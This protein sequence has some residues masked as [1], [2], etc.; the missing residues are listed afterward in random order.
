MLESKGIIKG[1]QRGVLSVFRE[2]PDSGNFFLTG[3]TALSDFY[4]GHRLS[5]DLVLFTC[6]EKLVR[7]F[8]HAL[9]SELRKKFK[10]K[11]IRRFETF[12]EFQAEEKGDKTIIQLAYDTPFRLEEP[13]LCD[14]GVRVS[15][16]DDLIADKLLAFFGRVEPRDAVDV[17]F[18]L[19]REN[20]RRLISLAEK[21][22]TGFDEYHLAAAFSGTGVFPDDIG[23]WPVEMLEKVSA[24]EIKNDFV[25][26]SVEL[27]DGI[28]KK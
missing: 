3:G 19:K 8:S 25:R 22:D 9:E 2:L 14:L 23:K 16:Y 24:A 26:L 17:Y 12:V 21:K 15:G 5:F 27:L 4:L 1:V 6:E 10:T 28:R 13:V 7:P 20:L 18:I 11:V